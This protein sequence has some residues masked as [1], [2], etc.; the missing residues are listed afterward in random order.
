MR[1]TRGFRLCHQDRLV[2]VLPQ[3]KPGYYVCY[4]AIRASREVV[5]DAPPEAI[6]D[7]LA[8]IKALPSWSSVHK[9]A[10]VIDTYADGRPHHVKVTAKLMGIVDTEVL[11]Y[12]WG[13]NWLVWDAEPTDRQHGQHV[14]YT[15]EPE[16]GGTRV[17]FDI[18]LEPSAPLLELLIKRGE[19]IVLDDAT[20]GLRKRVLG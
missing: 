18:T 2:A 13:P 9:R 19:K 8:D 1:P 3:R 15:L 11:E 14:E 20:E 5:I 10:E 16:G 7:A 4:V 17:R 12:H 6:M